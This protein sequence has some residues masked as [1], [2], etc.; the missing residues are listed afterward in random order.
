M[1]IQSIIILNT[2]IFMQ[3]TINYPSLLPISVLSTIAKG[4]P[5]P[6]ST[7]ESCNQWLSIYENCYYRNSI[8]YKGPMIF[9]DSD[10]NISLPLAS[11][12]NIKIYKRELKHSLIAI[13]SS[14]EQCEWENSNFLLYNIAGLRKSNVTYRNTVNYSEQC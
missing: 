10:N 2:L 9:A 1:T 5:T 4:S 6:G 12:V 13:Q 11:Y 3:K 8:F 7:H 14:G